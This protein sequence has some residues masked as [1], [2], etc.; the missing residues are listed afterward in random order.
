MISKK[1]IVAYTLMSLVIFFIILLIIDSKYPEAIGDSW[2]VIHNFLQFIGE[3]FIFIFYYELPEFLFWNFII[4]IGLM[5]T[6]II[7]YNL[8][9]KRRV[10]GSITCIMCM[11]CWLI[12]FE[13]IIIW[14]FLGLIINPTW[15]IQWKLIL[16]IAFIPLFF[17]FIF[18]MS[19]LSD[20]LTF[21][22]DIIKDRR[23]YSK[24]RYRIEKKN[25]VKLIHID[26]EAT[27]INTI[28]SA[29]VYL[30][31]EDVLHK[32]GE[33]NAISRFIRSIITNILYEIATHFN[34]WPRFKNKIF[35]FVGMKIGRDCVISQF[36]RVDGLLP[37]LI[38]I[39][40]HTIIGVSSNL[41]THTFL[42]R[43]NLRAFL[44]GPI[45]ICKF[46]RIA[47]NVTITPGVTIGE[48]A[49][50]AAGSLVNK[51]IPP[52]TLVGGVPAEIIKKLDPETYL[53][54]IEKDQWLRSKY[55]K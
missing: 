41:I 26:T 55:F 46:A 29:I 38:T 22:A 25:N 36:T 52:Y 13:L 6:Y 35:R 47:A 21:W 31:I 16:L 11:I 15:A 2:L 24:L 45:K 27:R 50:V 1:R 39:E 14:G 40:D 5:L 20:T 8:T 4:M 23:E 43:G 42:D 10:G 7:A 3:V 18:I 48:G 51:D 37:N 32:E 33:S 49:V 28:S 12:Q 53:P 44:Y 17:L 54:R 19:V 34:F 9:K 30:L